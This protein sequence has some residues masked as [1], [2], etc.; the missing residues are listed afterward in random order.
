MGCL[1]GKI[2]RMAY[3]IA[4]DEVLAK[5]PVNVRKLLYVRVGT[6]LEADA[7]RPDVQRTETDGGVENRFPLRRAR[8]QDMVRQPGVE[9]LKNMR[10]CMGGPSGAK[11]QEQQSPPGC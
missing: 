7:P 4:F 8:M 9:R 6:H 10:R 11:Q 2:I 3:L 5:L 1:S